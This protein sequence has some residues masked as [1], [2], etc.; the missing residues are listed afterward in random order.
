M[1]ASALNINSAIVYIILGAAVV[2]FVFA[3]LAERKLVALLAL[4]LFC[5]S[6]GALRLQ[7]ALGENQYSTWLESKQKVEGY[8]VQD[9]DVRLDKQL[10]TFRPKGFDQNILITANLDQ[11]FFYGDWIVA[12]GKLQEAKNFSDFDYQKYLERFN[13]YA[14]MGYPKILILKSHQLNPVKEFL[15]KVKYGFA[16]RVGGFIKEP[17]KSLLMGILIGARKTLPQN[18]VENFNN[19]GTSHIIAVSGFN[20]TIIISALGSLVYVFGRRASFWLAMLCLVAFVV[21]AG[22]SA[23]VIR[24]SVMGFLLLLSFRFGRQYSVRPALFFSG[25][26]ML[27]LNPRILFWDV[28]FQLSF[29]ATLGIVYFMPLLGKIFE[30]LG[31]FLG[32]KTLVL[33]TLSA[34]LATLPLIL[35]TFGRLSL[36]A[37]LVN[38]LILPAVPFAMLFGFLS[39]VPVLGQGFAF[40]AAG[41]LFYIIKITEIFARLPYSS[42]DLKISTPIFWVLV[43]LVFGLY[44]GLRRRIFKVEQ[45]QRV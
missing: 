31:D 2:V 18:I 45:I 22:A 17:Q 9:V 34:I 30:N 25:F 20:I 27:L 32:L 5:V 13:V 37:L 26:I 19:T 8:I 42:I 16:D 14:V 21:I 38:I 36:S 39:V 7:S 6:L 24:A 1:F 43:I 4:F 3:F 12:E 15:L 44:F 28:G 35:F 41:L 11:E 40:V 10:I 33:T 29:A 23:S